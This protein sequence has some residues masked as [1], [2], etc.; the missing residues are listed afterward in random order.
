MASRARKEGALQ[1]PSTHG[2]GPKRGMLHARVF[3]EE[4]ARSGYS[5]T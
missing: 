5:L 2:Y 4:Y 3:T 1:Y